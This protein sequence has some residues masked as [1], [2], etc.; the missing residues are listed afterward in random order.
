MSVSDDYLQYILER[1]QCV[2]NVTSKR[3]F[4]GVGIY[5]ANIF[6]ALIDD[7]TLYFKVDNANRNDYE[8]VGM[9]PFRP[10]GEKSYAMA[11]YTVPEEVLENDQSLTVWA[12]KAIAVARKKAK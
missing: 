1:L 2:G 8:D 9:Q 4:G 6:F 5:S 12:K 3:M 7:N 11:Y 10:Y